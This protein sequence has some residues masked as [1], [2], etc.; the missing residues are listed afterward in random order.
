[1]LRQEKS[2]VFNQFRI[3]ELSLNDLR[4]NVKEQI[5]SHPRPINDFMHSSQPPHSREKIRHSPS[6]NNFI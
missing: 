6:R 4:N 5:L 3:A 1:M 2:E